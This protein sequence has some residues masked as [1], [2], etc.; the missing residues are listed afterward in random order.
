MLFAF[1]WVILTGDAITWVWLV[2]R[3]K[4]EGLGMGQRRLLLLWLLAAAFAFEVLIST[5]VDVAGFL[6]ANLQIHLFPLFMLSGIPLVIVG[7]AE[8]AG[9]IN[10]RPTRQ[11]MTLVIVVLLSVFAA[12]VVLK[13][14]ND[15]LV[16]NKWLFFT[17]NEQRALA[18]ADSRLERRVIWEGLD[19]RLRE[20]QQIY[21]PADPARGNRFTIDKI[22]GAARYITMSE[23]IQRRSV[24]MNVPLPDISSTDRIY[25]NG[26]AQIY[27]R[28]PKTPYQP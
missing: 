5:V 13:A 28:V 7:G 24:R 22:D 26:S 9:W 4:R 3:F 14:T 11:V 27:H 12:T 25:D 20:I 15:P 16:S 6:G 1:N 18:W 10:S 2:V 17:G 23:V 21:Q 19:E 8:V